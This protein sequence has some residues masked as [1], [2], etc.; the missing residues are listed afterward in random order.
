MHEGIR[1][2]FVSLSEAEA[3]GG[4]EPFNRARVMMIRS[5]SIEKTST[6]KRCGWWSRFLREAKFKARC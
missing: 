6:P 3:F 1:A 4:I 5:Y 2:A